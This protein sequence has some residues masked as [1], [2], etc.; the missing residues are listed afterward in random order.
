MSDSDRNP[1]FLMLHVPKCAG[2]SIE[3]HFRQ[4][5]GDAM[6]IPPKRSRRVSIELMGRKYLNRPSTAPSQIRA[7]S[8]HFIGQS[9]TSLFPGRPVHRSVILRDPVRLILSWYNYR[10]ARYAASGQQSYDFV[11]HLRALP[12]DPVARFLLERWL[13]LPVWTIMSLS[14]AR[15]AAMLDQMLGGFELVTDVSGADALARTISDRLGVP[16]ALEH[17]NRSDDWADRTGWAPLKLDDLEPELV[18][19]IRHRT[20]LDTYLWRRWAMGEQV[21]FRPERPIGYVR[22][23]LR[24]AVYEVRRKVRRNRTP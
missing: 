22:Q 10:M 21:A 8:G 18:E 3:N 6:W 20:Q 24:R 5:L 17:V 7:V 4:H 9:V 12:P 2:T 1:V 13:K 11:T 15:R 16:G 14:A 19:E 23:E